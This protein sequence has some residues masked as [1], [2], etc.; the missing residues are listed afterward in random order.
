MLSFLAFFTNYSFKAKQ[1]YIFVLI[2]GCCVEE[3]A[4]ALTLGGGSYNETAISGVLI[5]QILIYFLIY[6]YIITV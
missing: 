2:S 4:L 6:S 5:R 1:S 3:A